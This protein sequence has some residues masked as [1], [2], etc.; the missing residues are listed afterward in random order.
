VKRSSPRATSPLAPTRTTRKTSHR[1]SRRSFSG[2][3][4]LLGALLLALTGAH[5]LAAAA[6]ELTFHEQSLDLPGA[7]AA[8][9]PAD[10]DGDGLRDLVVVVVYTEWDQIG[11]E[12]MTSMDQ[13]E[14]LVEVLTIVPTLLD[15]REVRLYRG[16]SD[17]DFTLAGEPLPL[18]LDVL[19]MET[20]PPGLPVIALTDAGLSALR[21]TPGGAAGG[22]LTLEPVLDAPPVLAGTGT[23]L[24]DLPLVADA[25]GDGTPDLLLPTAAGIAIYDGADLGI[26]DRPGIEPFA[27]VAYPGWS[28]D[29]GPESGAAGASGGL[30]LDV[31]LPEVVDA[32]GDGLPDL[33]FRSP[34]DGLDGASIAL[35]SAPG[36]FTPPAAVGSSDPTGDGNQ[37]GDRVWI[38]PVDERP[39]AEVVETISLND[40]DAGLRKEM[41][42]AREPRFRVRLHPLRRGLPHARSADDGTAGTALRTATAPTQTFEVRGWVTSGSSGPDDGDGP[43]LALPGGFQD[44]NGDGRADLVT[45]TNDIT[46]FKAMSILATRRL[47]L[48]LGFLAWCQQPD[49]GFVRAPGEPLTSKLRIN[50]NDL[51]IRQRSLF[52]GDFD[53]DGRQDF[54]QLGRDREIG[55]HLGGADCSYR[56]RPDAT[57]RLRDPLRDLALADA[58]DLDGDGR[59]DLAVTQPQ[60]VDEPGV[61]PPVRLDL[62]VSTGRTETT[63]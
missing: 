12:E 2:R 17:G 15:R 54:L 53:G 5:R 55:I 20:G 60:P 41:E 7:P 56:E 61:S 3:A 58:L 62:Y 14:G 45:V 35:Q 49:G 8:L 31:P 59:S 40:D 28:P 52:A 21:F 22:A 44:L 23:F 36:R 9:L 46:L 18:P 42:Q 32:D 43:H 47:T 33:L 30:R 13:V 11:I 51:E 16:R 29:S 4:S 37:D 10:V 19:S 24:A 48:E 27:T 6:P 63:R 34:K 57:I 39:G 26:A 50:L 38:G 25:T 1:P